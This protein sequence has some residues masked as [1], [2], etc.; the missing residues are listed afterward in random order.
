MERDFETKVLNN[1]EELKI[2]VAVIESKIND[3]LQRT[4]DKADEAY[5]I[6]QQN[7]KDLKELK[8][9]YTWL[10]RTVGA[11]IITA[12]IGLI[13]SYIKFK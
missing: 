12:L 10:S 8:S 13:F 4:K 9:K 1:L 11:A 6:S 7:E 2:R 3:D 5:T